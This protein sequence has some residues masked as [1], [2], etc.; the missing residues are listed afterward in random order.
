MENC[1]AYAKERVQYGKPI[2]SYQRI[3]HHLAGMWT[4]IQ[5][6]KRLLY[7]AAWLI[8]EGASDAPQVAMAKAW[9][10]QV[11]RR[12]TKVGVQIYGALGTTRDCDMGLYYRRAQQATP[13]FGDTEFHRETVARGLGL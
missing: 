9:L 8:D 1:T 2:G 11:Y 6:A 7:E 5:I 4:D 10:N 13:L 12:W 3:Q